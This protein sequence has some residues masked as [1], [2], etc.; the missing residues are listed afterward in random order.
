MESDYPD[1]LENLVESKSRPVA[2]PSFEHLL[3][4]HLDT[5]AF[6]VNAD[7]QLLCANLAFCKLVNRPVQTLRGIPLYEFE[8]EGSQEQWQE[9]WSMIQQQQSLLRSVQYQLPSGQLISVFVRMTY[10]EYE[11]K[12]VI[13]AFVSPQPS[14]D[15][16]DNM[17]DGRTLETEDVHTT[18]V[19]E[20]S[21]SSNRSTGEFKNKI[22]STICYQ[23]RSLLHIISFSN[24]LIRRNLAQWSA[25]EKQPYLDY[26]QNSVD[27][28]SDL[29]DKSVLFGRSITHDINPQP[30]RL[31]LTSFCHEI[32]G[33]MQPMFEV[34]QQRIVFS[35]SDDECV[36]D[37]YLLH[38]VLVNLL[39]NASKYSPPDSAIHFTVLCQQQGAIFQIQDAGI[40]IPESEQHQLFEP[41]YRGSNVGDRPGS[42]L[43]LAIVKKIIDVQGGKINLT[44]TIKFGTT[45]SFLLPSLE[46]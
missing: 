45:V 42:G 19:P 4:N 28:L 5:A 12:E 9:Q 8:W 11:G 26:I 17:G 31:N 35:G 37:P 20:D 21:E 44:S 6:C 18:L 27:Q 46:E 15:S 22:I 7:A 25:D 2:E 14:P 43:G 30:I 36:A 13:C 1:P 24:S 23:F 33:Y 39:S 38:V 29:L 41:F 34:N 3:L 10:S 32:M 40:G 16:S